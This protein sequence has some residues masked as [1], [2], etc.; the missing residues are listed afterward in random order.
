VKG[1]RLRVSELDYEYRHLGSADCDNIANVNTPGYVRKVADQVAYAAQG[2][3]AGVDVARTRL[4]T[5]RFLQAASL[6][7]GADAARQ[8][9][10][11]ELYDQIQNRFGDPSSDT[12][13]FA[14]IDQL[15]STYA[16]LAESPT[17][18][19]ARQDTIYKTKALFDEAAGVSRQIQLARQEADS[20]LQGAVETINPLLEEIDK[21]NKTIASGSAV[22]G[23]VTGAQ[24]TQLS[25]INQLSKYM[26]VKVEQ[27]ANGG[28]TLRTGSGMTLVGEGHATL[29]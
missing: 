14:K 6:S 18:S 4:A 15:F 5:D 28:V 9:V 25:L 16:G 23:D 20:R 19:A 26:D 17:S 1:V 12:G 11:Y 29:T 10:R 8:S 27:R 3:G 2:I 22:N 24:N 7:A 21:L 13:F